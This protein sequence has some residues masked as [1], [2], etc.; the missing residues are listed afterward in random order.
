MEG[1]WLRN[2]QEAGGTNSAKSMMHSTK[3]AYQ[4]ESPVAPKEAP[5]ALQLGGAQLKP[6]ELPTLYL[7]AV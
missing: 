2:I 4:I 6:R 7:K 3:C 1:I 5:D